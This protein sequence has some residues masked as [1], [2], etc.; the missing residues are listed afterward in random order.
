MVG[1]I[2]GQISPDDSDLKEYHLTIPEL[3]S[4]T[5]IN[6]KTLYKD[7]SDICS[8]LTGKV[9]SIS[10]P[11][12]SR[13]FL[14]TSW[15]A[16][17]EY[18]PENGYVSFEISK[19]LKPYLLNLKNHFTS[20]WQDQVVRMNCSYSHRMYEILKYYLDESQKKA[21]T[22]TF[23]I[24]EF[25]ELIWV[26]EGKYPLFNNFKR[27]VI[28]KT[29][30]ELKEVSDLEFKF[31]PI[32]RGRSI[33]SIKFSVWHSKA[34]LDIPADTLDASVIEGELAKEEDTFNA[35]FD[36]FD[37]TSSEDDDVT[38]WCLRVMSKLKVPGQAAVRILTS[39]DPEILKESLNDLMLAI[40]ENRIKGTRGAYLNGILKN[41]KKEALEASKN[42]LT[43]R[44]TVEKL[45]DISWADDINQ[46]IMEAGEKEEE[47]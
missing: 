33:H 28:E 9:I 7:I 47:A 29:Q 5:K 38:A 31:E 12:V 32:R 44:E 25:R 46:R 24:A 10:D 45:T 11:D 35:A 1:A 40:E 27:S 30:K 26:P 15:F 4:I 18:I 41:K 20:I 8:G 42:T 17:A 39:N 43:N 19:K 6:K 16:S 21:M 37:Y 34:T 13:G 23:E 14:H 36:R 2:V 22:K 3:A